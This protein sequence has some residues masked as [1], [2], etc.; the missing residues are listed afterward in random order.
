LQKT[1]TSDLEQLAARYKLV[2]SNDKELAKMTRDT[3]LDVSKVSSVL[4]AGS[5]MPMKRMKRLARL[6]LK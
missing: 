5:S 6:K 2:E 3:G 1:F 4:H